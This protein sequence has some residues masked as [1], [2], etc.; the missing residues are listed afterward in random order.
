MWYT[1]RAYRRIG[2]PFI[3]GIAIINKYIVYDDA[4]MICYC[5]N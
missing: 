3:K 1:D 2:S 4:M 5:L